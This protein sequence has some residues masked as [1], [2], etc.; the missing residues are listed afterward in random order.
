MQQE[1]QFWRRRE[2][3]FTGCR[4]A[5]PRHGSALTSFNVNGVNT[6]RMGLLLRL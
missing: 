5:K 2:K 3:H 1:N 6:E 4:P